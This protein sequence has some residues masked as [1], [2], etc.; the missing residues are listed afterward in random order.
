MNNVHIRNFTEYLTVV[1]NT[2]IE[3]EK[4]IPISSVFYYAMADTQYITSTGKMRFTK[5]LADDLKTFY[6]DIGI[7]NIA[8][9][10]QIQRVLLSDSFDFFVICQIAFFLG[11][12]IKDLTAPQITKTQIEKEQSTHYIKDKILLDWQTYDDELSPILEQIAKDIYNGSENVRPERVSERLIYREMELPAHRLE[13]LPKCRVIFERYTES[14][15]ENWARRI[16][17]A[18]QKLKVERKD[19]P[20][21]WSD[22]RL[23]SGVKKENINKVIPFIPKY[24]DKITTMR[25]IRLIE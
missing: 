19:T 15:E 9:I 25:I 5:R 14:Y 8:S 17:W 1:F 11:M 24:T 23:L 7:S 22:I 3:F 16:V 21:Y 20:F 18:Y 12:S 10:H 13:K 4:D 2:H 6:E